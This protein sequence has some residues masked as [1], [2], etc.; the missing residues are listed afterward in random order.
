ME[1]FLHNFP[2]DPSIPVSK[3]SGR[4]PSQPQLAWACPALKQ[5]SPLPTGKGVRGSQRAAVPHSSLPCNLS[6]P[7]EIDSRIDGA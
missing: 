2:C 7:L 6:H 1:M 3:L 5:S 4:C